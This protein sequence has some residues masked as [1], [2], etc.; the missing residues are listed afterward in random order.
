MTRVYDDEAKRRV[1]ARAKAM[2]K[3][4]EPPPSPPMRQWGSTI[5]KAQRDQHELEN[6]LDR[7]V[8]GDRLALND[9]DTMLPTVA[10]TRA[11]VLPERKRPTKMDE[12]TQQMNAWFVE[13]F[14]ACI[15][16][17]IEAINKV[18]KS[19]NETFEDIGKCVGEIDRELERVE[20]VLDAFDSDIKKIIG[21]IGG[22]KQSDGVTKLRKI[23][24]AI[25]KLRS[26]MI[27]AVDKKLKTLRRAVVK[28][29]KASSATDNVT[30]LNA[31]RKT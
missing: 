2:L 4:K 26:E 24:D 7:Y 8:A 6:Q 23:D 3:P 1:M 5:T 15:K 9:D 16:P 27:E 20:K 18:F 14:N 13:S 31:K 22:D 19:N 29:H 28:H 17:H 25:N 12:H 11:V 21:A 30:N 10:E